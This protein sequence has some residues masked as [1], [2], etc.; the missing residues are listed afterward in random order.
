M[1]TP[2]KPPAAKGVSL[3]VRRGALRRFANLTKKAADL[4]V[5][6]SWDRRTSERRDESQRQDLERRK[7]DRR[8]EPPFTWKVADFVVVGSGKK[9]K[10]RQRRK[11]TP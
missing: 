4:P 8:Q 2:R 9:S 3:V 10:K 1:G 5:V 11:K 6:V 7:S